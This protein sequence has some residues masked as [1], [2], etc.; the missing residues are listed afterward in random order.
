[1]SDTGYAHLSAREAAD[2]LIPVADTLV[3]CHVHP[4]ADALGSAFSLREI[5]R[6]LG[7]RAYC[8]CQDEIPER[9]HFLVGDLQDSILRERL[10]ADFA[11][12]RIVSVDTASPQQMGTLYDVYGGKVDLMI[13]HHGKGE[14][15][16]DGW[17]LPLAAATGE[18]IC[19]IVNQLAEQGYEMPMARIAHLLYAAISSDTGCFR[20]NNV[21]PNTHRCAAELLKMAD[22]GVFDPADINHRLFEVK[23]AKLLLAEKLGFDRL[24][25]FADGR[26]GILDFPWHIKEKYELLDEHLETLVDI[27]RGLEGVQVAVAIRQPGPEGVYRASMRSSCEVDV[28]EV[29][30]A[31]GGG[32]HVRA[33]GCTIICDGGMD[34]V[35]GQVAE[36]L[37]IAMKA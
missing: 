13:D 21:T 25:L 9:L 4:D 7:S 11:P 26:I 36:A 5:L 28:S 16:A 8:V 1:M 22:G 12:T 30:A 14:M 18:M 17:I 3:I 35:V 6:V 33:A 31:F 29:C 20:Y 23:S 15:Y 10:P 24:H 2:R 34:A 19:E 32:G 27:P 37:M